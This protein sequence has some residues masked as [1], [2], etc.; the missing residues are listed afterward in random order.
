MEN[1]K[2]SALVMVVAVIMIMLIILNFYYLFGRSFNTYS[3]SV[4]GALF[5]L[6]R[7]VFGFIKSFILLSIQICAFILLLAIKKQDTPFNFK[8][9]WLLKIIAILL[10]SIE[11]LEFIASRIPYEMLDGTFV[12]NM[13]YPSGNMLAVGIVVYCV[14]VVFKHGITLQI[15]SDE[16]L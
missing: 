2:K 4:N 13:F 3:A 15:Q 7:I 9:V 14:S 8:N 16:T 11:P 6:G 5:N 1:Y 10:F 12:T